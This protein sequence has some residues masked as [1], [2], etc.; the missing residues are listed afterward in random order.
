[1]N[2]RDKPAKSGLLPELLLWAA[3][4]G[5]ACFLYWPALDYMFKMWRVPVYGGTDYSHGPVLPLVSLYA[6]W[7]L[8]HAL[9]DAPKRTSLVGLLIV[10]ISLAAH[11]AGMRSGFLRLSLLSALGFL[12][13][14]GLTLYGPAVSRLLLF[15]VGYLVFCIPLNVLDTFSFQLRVAAAVLS[16]GI[17]NG[18]GIASQRVGTAIHSA[19]GGA[20]AF[21]VAD[22]CSG[23][24]SLLALTAIAAAYAYFT[25]KTAWRRWLMFSFAIP[26][27]IAANVVRIISIAMV[28]QVFGQ[29]NAMK[30]YHDYS[31]YIV[32][33]VATLLLMGSGRLLAI[34]RRHGTVPKGSP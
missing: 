14:S 24:R 17:L 33:A 28:A 26:I 10:A 8:R 25:Q 31:G 15:P 27:A 5:S 12:W 11:W 32:F 16:N 9:R 18:V 22:P 29:H 2:N 19:A 1:M 7:R 34:N 4:L 6:I 3:L 13:G 21:D 23:I 30:V 20:F